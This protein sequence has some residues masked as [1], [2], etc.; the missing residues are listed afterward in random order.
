M[1]ISFGGVLLIVAFSDKDHI[2]SHSNISDTLIFLAMSMNLLSAVIL[3]LNNV[4]VRQVRDVH[5]AIVCMFQGTGTFILSLIMLISYRSMFHPAE[6]RFTY[7]FTMIDYVYIL[8]LALSCF[9]SQIFYVQS[10]ASDKA[11]R[12]SSLGFLRLVFGYVSDVLVFNYHMN[13]AEI[14]GTLIVI[15][16][17][18]LVFKLNY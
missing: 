10:L 5:W 13:L 3:A 18:S 14:T 7:D 17:A 6:T 2:M 15:G 11:A 9:I 4:L 8:C 16:C 1:L 12:V